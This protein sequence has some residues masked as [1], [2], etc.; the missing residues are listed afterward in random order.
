VN[1]EERIQLLL[2]KRNLPAAAT[3][4]VEGYGPEVF[5]FLVNV[6]RDERDAREVY[7]QTCEDLWR[8]IG[9]FQG[10]SKM[11]TWLYVLAGNAMRRYRRS[12]Q[13]RRRC[14]VGMSELSAVAERTR[15]RTLRHLRTSVKDQFV[16]IREGLREKDRALLILR[17]DRDMSWSE[18][19]QT[20]SAKGASDEELHRLEDRLRKRF[21]AVKKEIR[22]RAE[23]LGLLKEED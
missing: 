6:L 19:A 15:T 13:R 20:L 9:R 4:T 22:T 23:E 12:R 3:V 16:T 2:K 17:V 21:Q 14:L 5:G 11:R 7:A 8:G 1:L 18:I 10:R